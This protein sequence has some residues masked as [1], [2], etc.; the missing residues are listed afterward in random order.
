[1]ENMFYVVGTIVVMMIGICVVYD[2]INRKKNRSIARK[3]AIEVGKKVD[4][5]NKRFDQMEKTLKRVETKLGVY[6]KDV[7]EHFN[8]DNDQYNKNLDLIAQDMN[9][10]LELLNKQPEEKKDDN[11]AFWGALS[12]IFSALMNYI[13]KKDP[14][15]EE[16]SKDCYG[17]QNTETGEVL[18]PRFDDLS[19]AYNWL[20]DYVN[21]NNLNEADFTVGKVVQ[22][23]P[24]ETQA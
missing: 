17:I 4:E 10:V 13:E 2:F 24:E 8:K 22:K 14:G 15:N 9:T 11:S 7:R 5:F 19:E 12:G 20:K 1:M 23:Q 18:E 16:Q 21:E 6:N 3:D